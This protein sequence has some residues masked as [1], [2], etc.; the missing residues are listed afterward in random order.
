MSFLENARLQTVLDRDDIEP[1]EGILVPVS[2]LKESQTLALSRDVTT[3]KRFTKVYHDSTTQSSPNKPVF[4]FSS[5]F[6]KL[7]GTSS[8]GGETEMTP[9]VDKS[10]VCMRYAG[11]IGGQFVE[12]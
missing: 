8:M 2:A 7:W 12:V 3:D 1:G 11:S 6:R 5:T 10:K 9:V 4:P